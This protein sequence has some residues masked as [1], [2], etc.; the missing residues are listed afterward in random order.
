M[1]EDYFSFQIFF[2]FLRESLEIIVILSILITIVRKALGIKDEEENLIFTEISTTT[3]A[4]TATTTSDTATVGTLDTGRNIADPYGTSL[5]S[6]SSLGRGLTVEEEE[7]MYDFSGEFRE[8]ERTEVDNQEKLKKYNRLKFQIWSGGILGLILCLVIGSTFIVV[9]YHIGSDLWSLSEHYYEGALSIIAS[10]IMSVMGL[11]FLRM[12]KLREKFRVKLA[13]IIYSEQDHILKRNGNDNDNK[14]STFS[15]R[16]AF[17]ILPFVT[18]LREGLEAVVFVGGVG[19]DQP[20]TSIPLSMLAAVS[21]SL[22]FGYFFFKYSSSLSLKIC[23]SITTCFMYLIAAG[24]FSKGVWQFELQD[25]VN[26]CNGQ[27]MSEVGNGPG[28]YDISRSIWHVNC[29]NGERDGFWMLLTAIFGWTNSATYGSIISYI[30]YWLILILAI[31]ILIIEEKYGYISFL[32]ISW[33]KKR[34][35]KR[36]KIA[37]TSIKMKQRNEENRLYLSV[38]NARSKDSTT[39]LITH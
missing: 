7:E 5:V 32:P 33:Q 11:F 23:L 20:L 2:I 35:V 10:I 36:I 26:K 13:G 18:S 6:V 9:F 19:I 4:A 38:R 15:S 12:G 34:I 17:F 1:F 27:D 31:N 21:I 22:I 25:Y 28:S 30:I 8:E 14:A 3:T 29:C 24:L 16:Y 37:D 39:P